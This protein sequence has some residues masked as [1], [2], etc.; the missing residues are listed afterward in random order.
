MNDIVSHIG[1]DTP[2]SIEQ[3][4]G[5]SDLI[6]IG[7]EVGTTVKDTHW[8]PTRLNVM[9]SYIWTFPMPRLHSKETVVR[10][11]HTILEVGGILLPTGL[12]HFGCKLEGRSGDGTFINS[13]RF[14]MS[15]CMI[16][17]V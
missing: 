9:T 10:I 6:G 12:I 1:L 13:P 3:N 8:D 4:V 16:Y 14:N 5:C 7:W 11:H 15:E 17:V 2:Y